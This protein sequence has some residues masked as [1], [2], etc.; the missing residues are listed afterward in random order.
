MVEGVVGKPFALEA[1][2]RWLVAQFAQ[3][4]A[5]LSWA[6]VNGAWQRTDQV[7]W[8]YLRKGEIANVPDPADWMRAQM[9]AEGVA[10]A[11]GFLTSRRAGAFVEGEGFDTGCH[12]WAV[13]TLGLSNALRAG[14]PSGAIASPGTINLLVCCSQPLTTEAALEALALTAEAKALAMIE[15]GVVSTRTGQPASGTGT[16]Y[17]AIAWPVPGDRTPYA[18]KHTPAGAAIAQATYRAV[19]RGIADWLKERDAE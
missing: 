5:V 9:H 2:G 17:L 12:A 8:L 11:V 13:G 19:S 15:S 18:G 4:R 14:D 7:V 1:R 6:V 3:P 10:G 16:D